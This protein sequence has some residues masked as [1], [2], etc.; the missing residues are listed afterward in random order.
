MDVGEAGNEAGKD[1]SELFNGSWGDRLGGEEPDFASHQEKFLRFGLVVGEPS[2]GEVGGDVADVR[3][4]DI[5]AKAIKDSVLTAVESTTF[6]AVCGRTLGALFSNVV[7]SDGR[8]SRAEG[9]LAAPAL[10]TDD[11]LPDT[12]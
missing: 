4:C 6:P 9:G 7:L 2:L 3:L 11:K 8:V 10:M 5:F 1:G 12:E